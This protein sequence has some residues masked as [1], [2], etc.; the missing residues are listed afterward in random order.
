MLTHNDLKQVKEVVKEETDPLKEKIERIENNIDKV[1]KIVT[2]TQQEL[3][4]SNLKH[5][6]LT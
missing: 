6:R 2:T 3:T 4:S 5:L 1:L